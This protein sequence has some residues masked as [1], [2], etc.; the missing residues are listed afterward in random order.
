MRP[1]KRRAT[2]EYEYCFLPDAGCFAFHYVIFDCSE[3]SAVF[4]NVFVGESI[5]EKIQFSFHWLMLVS[6]PVL[7]VE[8]NYLFFT[9]KTVCNKTNCIK[10]SWYNLSSRHLFYLLFSRP[11]QNRSSR[12][13]W[14]KNSQ[15]PLKNKAVFQKRPKN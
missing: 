13:Q 11:Y 2:H 14:T 1:L 3:E 5:W 4:L 7:V 12:S 15:I 8:L 9:Y 10:Y 6:K